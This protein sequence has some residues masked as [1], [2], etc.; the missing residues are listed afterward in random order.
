MLSYLSVWDLTVA[1][2]KQS[3]DTMFSSLI[4]CDVSWKKS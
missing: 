1:N 4:P 2:M 3:S